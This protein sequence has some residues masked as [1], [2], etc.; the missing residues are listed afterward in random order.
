MTTTSTTEAFLLKIAWSFGRAFLAA[1]LVG[2]TGV[3][4]SPN[5][6]AAKAALV[7]LAIAAVTAGVRAVQA[8]IAD[9]TPTVPTDNVT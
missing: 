7:A 5:W 3:L 2:V 6:S 4:A 9:P 1:F 8:L